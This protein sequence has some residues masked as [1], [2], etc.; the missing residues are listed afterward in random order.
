MPPF[1][2]EAAAWGLAFGVYVHPKIQAVGDAF[3]YHMLNSSSSSGSE[4]ECSSSNNSSM[5]GCSTSNSNSNGDTAV[6]SHEGDRTAAAAA[7]AATAAATAAA[8]PSFVSVHLRRSDFS[9]LGR[10]ANLETAGSLLLHLANRVQAL[11]VKP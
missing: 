3:L 6:S 8:V 2:D 10:A 7:A 11:A 9:R 5:K 4:S 1:P